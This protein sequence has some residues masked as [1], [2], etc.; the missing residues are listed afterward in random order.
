VEA[1]AFKSILK[2]VFSLTGPLPPADIL[3]LTYETFAIYV[4]LASCVAFDRL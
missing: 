4:S 2:L 3:L 1:A